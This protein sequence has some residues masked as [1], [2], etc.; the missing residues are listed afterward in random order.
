TA[1][2]AC[3][4]G[5]TAHRKA[6]TSRAAACGGGA[7]TSTT[8]AERSRSRLRCDPGRRQAL[9]VAA[10]RRRLT[11]LLD[12]DLGLYNHTVIK[13]SGYGTRPVRP[14]RRHLPRPG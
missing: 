13:L 10:R 3:I 12:N 7:A 14:P 5:S 9:D 1:S 6:A 4:S 8:G 2:G 11:S